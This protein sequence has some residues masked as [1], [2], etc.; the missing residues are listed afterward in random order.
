LMIFLAT[1]ESSENLLGV[2]T[3]ASLIN[4]PFSDKKHWYQ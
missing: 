4:C 1:T 2:Y 3:S